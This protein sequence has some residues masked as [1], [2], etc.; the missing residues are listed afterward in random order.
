[1]RKYFI[2][3]LLSL[4]IF[5]GCGQ[6]KE[7]KKFQGVSAKKDYI[8]EG[9][10]HLKEGDIPRAIYSFDVAIKNDPTNITNYI[11][12][13][14]VYMR[15]N[16]F[17]RAVD[18]LSAATRVDQNN[19]EVYYLL[20]TSKAFQGEKEDAIKMAQRSVDIFMNQRDED[21][22]KASVALL[23]SLTEIGQ[24]PATESVDNAQDTEEDPAINFEEVKRKY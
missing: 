19:G 11:I 4:F 17:D 23:K 14:Q 20:A 15:L 8:T 13:G 7:E 9:M 10:N 24:P 1:M 6:K 21:R 3:A 16:N 5:S 22:F 2:L 12:L 18:T